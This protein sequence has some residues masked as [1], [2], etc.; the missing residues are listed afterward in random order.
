LRAR[1]EHIQLEGLSDACFLGKL[2]VLPT[3]VI[4]DWKVLARYIHYSLFGIII[5]N[6]EKKFYNID[7][8][9]QSC[10]TLCLCCWQTG[11]IS[12]SICPWQAFPIWLIRS[13][14]SKA[15]LSGSTQ[16]GFGFRD[17]LL[18]M[19]LALP[20]YIRQRVDLIKLFWRKFTYTFF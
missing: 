19:L 5:S 10:K 15:C 7:T 3:N 18:G 1:P 13:G 20:A 11:Q 16:A 8:W 4:L 2:L 17:S 6:E 14:K 12:Q 9:S